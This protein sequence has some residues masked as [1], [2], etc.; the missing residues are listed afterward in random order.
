LIQVKHIVR[1]RFNITKQQEAVTTGGFL[2]TYISLGLSNYQLPHYIF[3][4]FPLAA[5]ITARFLHSLTEEYKYQKLYKPLLYAHF[6]L[7]TLLW[8]ALL[9]LLYLT[10]SNIP[11]FATIL[12]AL[13][14]IAYVYIF[15]TQKK[16]RHIII[17]IC[18]F[19]IAGINL[20]LNASFYP[21]LLKYQMGSTAGRWIARQKIPI[22]NIRVYKFD[23]LRSLHFYAKGNIYRQDSLQNIKAGDW[24]ITGKEN[25][26]EISQ[27]GLKYDTFLQ[28]KDFHVSR[29]SLKFLDPARREKELKPYVIIKIK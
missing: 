19:T 9:A 8:L 29:L 24:I 14:M 5:V 20:F 11:A 25:L 18:L 6:I 28:G 17:T 7:F 16:R 1:K 21:S 22:E 13:L 3:V 2:L 15:L 10:F 26:S 4:V 27:N 23:A 12:A